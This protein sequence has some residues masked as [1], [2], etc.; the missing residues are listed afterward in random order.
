MHVAHP[1][2][3][4]VT[5]IHG[6]CTTIICAAAD[7]RF[8]QRGWVLARVAAE[9]RPQAGIRSTSVQLRAELHR[10]RA[11]L[12]QYF[13]LMSHVLRVRS[14]FGARANSQICSQLV[15]RIESSRLADAGN[16]HPVR[17]HYTVVAFADALLDLNSTG[18]QLNGVSLSLAF[19]LVAANE[20]ATFTLL[21][22]NA[23]RDIV[24]RLA[25]GR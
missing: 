3:H 9:R 16:E 7:E 19:S 14:R 1:A 5:R 6:V 13:T 8:S 25:W 24:P 10:R 23:A 17:L 22:R 15:C 2:S 21:C 4:H 12:L 18:K 11:P 20:R